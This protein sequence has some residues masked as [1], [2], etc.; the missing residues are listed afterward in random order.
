MTVDRKNN[1]T[2]EKCEN[3]RVVLKGKKSLWNPP[4]VSVSFQGVMTPK[5]LAALALA[6][7]IAVCL[8]E[9][10]DKYEPNGD[11]N[12][13]EGSSSLWFCCRLVTSNPTQCFPFTHYVIMLYRSVYNGKGR[14]IPYITL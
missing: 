11:V 3:Q 13:V 7:Y 1:T 2:A 10:V 8:N 5:T 14:H 12:N 4:A 6:T 9:N